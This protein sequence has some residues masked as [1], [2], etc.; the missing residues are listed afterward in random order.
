MIIYIFDKA[1]KNG[2]LETVNYLREK[3]ADINKENKNGDTALLW[4][5]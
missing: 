4:G 3:G 2:H 1:S 5:N